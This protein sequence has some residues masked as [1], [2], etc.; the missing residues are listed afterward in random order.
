MRRAVL[1]S[2]V[3]FLLCAMLVVTGCSRDEGEPG[4]TKGR[5]PRV[6]VIGLDG[7][8]WKI[9]DR[10]SAAGRLPTFERLRR[11]GATGVFMSEPP[12]LSPIVWTTIGTGRSP[13]E[14]GI[15]GFL[16]LRDGA[17]EPVR[18]DERRVRA[19][20]NVATDYD[21]PVGVIGW[22]SSW[23]AEPVKGYL[24]SDRVGH[25]QVSGDAAK[26]QGASLAYPA[27]ALAIVDRV[28]REVEAEITLDDLER[29]YDPVPAGAVPLRPEKKTEDAFLGAVRTTELY[30]RIL[31]L[32]EERFDPEI[33]AV[34]FEGTDSVGHLFAHFAPPPMPGVDPAGQARFGG[35]FDRFYEHI[36][37]VLKEIV[38]RVDPSR[39]T[40]VIVSDHGFRT[41]ELRPLGAVDATYANQAPAWHRDE[42]AILMWGRGV[43]RGHALA[44][45]TVYD[46]MPTVLRLAGLPLSSKLRGY[47]IDEALDDTVRATPITTVDDYEARGNRQ[48]GELPDLDA[49][50]E[51]ARLQALGYIG[52]AA[53]GAAITSLAGGDGQA[54]VPLN[55][56][57]EAIIRERAGQKDAALEIY[58]ALQRDAPKFPLG[59]LGEAMIQLENREPADALPLLRRAVE[60]DPDFK[61]AWS[62]LGDAALIT[63]N[64][65]EAANAFARVLD[66]EP[67]NAHAAL[68]L[69]QLLLRERQIKE[70]GG[71]FSLVANSPSALPHERALANT[72]LASVLESSQ[73]LD[74]AE[75]AY[76][77]ALDLVPDFPAALERYANLELFRGR[78]EHGVALLARLTE[79]QPQSPAAWGLYSR[80]LEIAG[81]RDEAKQARARAE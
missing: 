52:D 46:F 33:S 13:L 60:I 20:W 36:D 63:G 48:T 72:G 71:L 10:L 65:R 1:A 14:H 9:I 58:R 42:G 16:T 5:G 75:A 57:N 32:L 61:L 30:R 19:F 56:Y 35:T 6:L 8:D 53:S 49:K 55:R 70:S 51:L 77:R 62:A 12:L 22:Y 50:E 40:L 21:M 67:T 28:R 31:P 45:S 3:S 15:F 64:T 68:S 34:Y 44:K 41:E 76:R 74:D 17:T 24:V 37:T 2:A 11:E 69:A 59:Y 26:A 23:P 73:R 38:L 54:G 29:F 7:L 27:D 18:S 78:T 66:L 81:R 39:T 79:V 80:A 25:H 47:P 4:A 43:K